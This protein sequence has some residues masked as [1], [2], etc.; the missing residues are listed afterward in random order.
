MGRGKS[1]AYE[2]LIVELYKLKWED[3]EVDFREILR[4]LYVEEEKSIRTLAKDFNV[5]PS[6]IH[7]W[8]KSNGIARRP[9]RC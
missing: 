3:N 2:H 1:K 4:R 8:L 5:S 6:T 7:D 9:V